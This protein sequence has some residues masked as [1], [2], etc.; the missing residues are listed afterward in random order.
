MAETKNLPELADLHYDIDTAFKKDKLNLLLNQKPIEKW[1][2][3]HPFATNV[4]YL[5]IDKV[6]FMLT[7]IFQEWRAEVIG[8]SQLFNAVSCHVRLHYLNPESGEWSYHDGLGAVGIQ[9]D[10]G[11]QASDLSAIKSN[12]V[13]LALPASKSYAIKDAAEH[14]GALFGRDLNR[15]DAIQ[16]SGAYSDDKNQ[17]ELNKVL[18]EIERITDLESLNLYVNEQKKFFDNALFINAVRNRQTKLKPTNK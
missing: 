1:I 15:K 2:K 4:S 13:M 11:K 17:P 7:R 8:Y 6:E 5:P 12:A 16:F 3:K 14:L 10:A 18:E 9:L